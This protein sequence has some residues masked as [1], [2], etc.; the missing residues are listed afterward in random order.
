MPFRLFSFTMVI[1]ICLGQNVK[2]VDLDKKKKNG[3]KF[4]NT[5]KRKN[6]WWENCE[7]TLLWIHERKYGNDVAY[8]A[9]VTV[10]IFAFNCKWKFLKKKKKKLN[11]LHDLLSAIDWHTVNICVFR[12]HF[13]LSVSDLWFRI[14]KPHQVIW[15]L[16]QLLVNY[17]HFKYSDAMPDE[18]NKYIS[19]A[20]VCMLR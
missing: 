18:K 12:G 9:I 10:D 14:S 1:H 2:I 15:N 17:L 13:H 7:I 20:M 5:K 16:F 11:A 19:H 8:D 4:R 6:V 3:E